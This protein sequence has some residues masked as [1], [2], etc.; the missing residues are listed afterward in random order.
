MPSIAQLFTFENQHC[1][2]NALQ[3]TIFWIKGESIWTK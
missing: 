3:K 1:I 2:L